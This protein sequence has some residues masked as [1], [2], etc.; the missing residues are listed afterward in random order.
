MAYGQDFPKTWLGDSLII[1]A[2][3]GVPI[4]KGATE[5]ISAATAK[6]KDVKS[7]KMKAADVGESTGVWR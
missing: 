6:G 2:S 7:K 1:G 3:S 5:T 4:K